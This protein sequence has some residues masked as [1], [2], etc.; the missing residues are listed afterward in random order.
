M[1]HLLKVA[2]GEKK[3]SIAGKRSDLS[4]ELPVRVTEVVI[5]A[6]SGKCPLSPGEPWESSGSFLL[7]GS[8]ATAAHL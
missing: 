3:K 7:T 1:A 5:A 2:L 4:G 8:R 6:F